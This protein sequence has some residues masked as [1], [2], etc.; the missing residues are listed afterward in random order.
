MPGRLAFFIIIGL[1]VSWLA[2]AGQHR[3]VVVHYGAADYRGGNQNWSVATDSAGRKFVANND[4]LLVI[5][6]SGPQLHVYPGKTILRSVAVAGG[7]VYTGSFE[8]FGYWTESE[9]RTWNYQPLEHLV[10]KDAFR[11]EEIWRIVPFGGKIYFQSFGNIFVY[12]GQTI[13]RLHL[14]GPVLFL[15]NAGGRLLVQRIRGGIYEIRGDTLALIPGTERFAQTE[16][17]TILPYG[18]GQLVIGT[19][20]DG[21]FLLDS[22]NRIQA[23]TTE[24]DELLSRYNLN[25]G[26]R[27]GEDFAFGTILKGVVIVDA[28]GK[29]RHHIHTGNGLQNNTILSLEPDASGNLWAGL[30][31]GIDYIWLRAP[32]EVYRERDHETGSVYAAA[33][34]KGKLYI[35]TN[36]GIYIYEPGSDGLLKR[37]GFLEGSQGQVWFLKEIDGLLYCGLND[38]TYAFDGRK[39]LQVSAV[40]GG[41]DLRR[42]FISGKEHMLQ[43]TYNELV[44]YARQDGVWRAARLLEGWTAPVRFME[45]DQLGR[46]F[47]G[48]AVWG[49][50]LAVPSPGLDSIADYQL[51]DEQFGV[52]QVQNQVF[53]VDGRIV[54]PGPEGFLQWD[55]LRSVFVPMADLNKQ[56]GKFAVATKVVPAGDHR[57]WLLL[58]DEAA[59]Y[60]LRLGQAK[61]LYRLI[62]Q[63]FNLKMVKGYEQIVTL[64]PQSYLFCLEDGFALLRLPQ[65]NTAISPVVQVQADFLNSKSAARTFDTRKGG[66]RMYLPFSYNTAMF[67]F[68]VSGDVEPARMYQ[69][70]LGGIDSDWHQWSANTIAEYSRLPYGNYTLRVRTHDESG[71]YSGETVIHFRIRPPWYL[72]WYAYLIYA[73]L[74]LAFV[75][76]LM[77]NHRRRQLKMREKE[78]RE[79]NERIKARNEQAEAELIRLSNERL[80]S[81]VVS[82]TMELAKNTMAMI[83]K[84]ELLIDIREE[85]A[86]QKAQLGPRYPD[87]FHTRINK[88]IESGLNSEHDWEM[89]EHL[90]D[91]AHENFFRRLKEAYPELTASDFRLCAYLRMNLSSKEIAPLLNISVRG[92]EEKRYRLRKKLNL[93]PDQNLTEFIIGF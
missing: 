19:S 6:G 58:P 75:M 8:A 76:L 87:K 36:Q 77:A 7:R 23:W 5:D 31:K 89:F 41:Y 57:Y 93:R 92:V 60:E 4:G 37:T 42:L 3:Y 61:I 24:A 16:V 9:R 66:S 62:F 28:G 20:T 2:A 10:G 14:P 90:F 38:G 56:L 86:N 18:D 26:A 40:N 85:L 13:H 35:G 68:A 39:L 82:K 65:R 67:R 51:V 64:G 83:R 34:Y 1:W 70:M 88:L 59:L 44:E 78:L 11:N 27:L 33:M 45:A 46:L 53:G 80:Q 91:Q 47:L 17:K 69:W 30:D 81:E 29:L 54:V 21:L 71:F 52:P 25:N 32:V 49:L 22:N 43:S 63:Q 50:Y 73:L 72:S 55:A 15:M 74:T 12:D 48:H 79:E 84:N